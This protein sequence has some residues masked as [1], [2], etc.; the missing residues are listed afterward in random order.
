M[1]CAAFTLPVWTYSAQWEAYPSSACLG[2]A[3]IGALLV[4]A[5][6]I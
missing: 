1:L 4:V 3:A 5:G 2:L 6:L